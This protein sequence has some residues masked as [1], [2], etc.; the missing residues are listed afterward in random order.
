MQSN[1][2]KF[3]LSSKGYFLKQDIDTNKSQSIRLTSDQE[4]IYI[5]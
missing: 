4:A 5:V 3:S 1:M 2:G